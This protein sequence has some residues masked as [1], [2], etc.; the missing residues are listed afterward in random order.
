MERSGTRPRTTSPSTR[1]RLP[2]LG[3]TEQLVALIQR[4]FPPS[5]EKF[6]EVITNELVEIFVNSVLT[7][8]ERE[9]LATEAEN[10]EH[11]NNEPSATDEKRNEKLDALI[12]KQAETFGWRISLS[13]MV[14]GRFRVWEELPN[15]SERF[16]Q[17]GKACARAV[18]IMQKKEPPPID[19]PGLRRSKVVAV[20]EL[21]L[22]L[23]NLRDEFSIAR[24]T[25]TAAVILDRF[26]AIVTAEPD[27]FEYIHQNLDSWKKFLKDEYGS[28]S[29]KAL[30]VGARSSRISPAGLFD[31]WL[32]SSKGY[33]TDS[34]RQQLSRMAKT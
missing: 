31:T 27:T 25:P 11:S 28:S 17:F 10:L 12:L 13:E 16:E 34:V 15:G 30:A 7:E 22:L 1:L 5:Q 3:P 8:D 14:Q 24:T 2:V 19:D 9:S 33:A 23:K 29:I 6:G 18:R 21:R 32:A 4:P 26:S 20:G